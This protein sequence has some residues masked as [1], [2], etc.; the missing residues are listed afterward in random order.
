[1][2]IGGS[3]AHRLKP[4]LETL[5][6]LSL[7]IT[8]LDSIGATGTAKAFPERGKKF[9]TGNTTLKEWIPKKEA[10]DEILDCKNENK[11]SESQQVRVAYQCPIQLKYK[12]N[13][14]EEEVLPYTF[15]DSLAL[16]NLQL[17]RDYQDPKGLLKK[18]KAA[19][20]E[21]TL[22]KASKKMFESLDTA[23]KAEMALELFFLTEPSEL[24][25]PAYISAG[26]EWLEAKLVE[27]NQNFSMGTNDGDIG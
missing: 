14:D 25:P 26:L 23:S 5:G 16:S 24:V 27:K 10:L 18:L 3:H 13:S 8:D 21:E 17:F 9:R 4:L 12:D 6:I 20:G 19:L 1:L 15:E 11:Q 2:E 7:V 22:S